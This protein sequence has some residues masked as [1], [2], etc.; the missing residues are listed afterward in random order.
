MP[1]ARMCFAHAHADRLYVGFGS[2]DHWPVPGSKHCD[3]QKP[4]SGQPKADAA[5]TRTDFSETIE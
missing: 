4:R 5:T 3:T 1:P 2:S